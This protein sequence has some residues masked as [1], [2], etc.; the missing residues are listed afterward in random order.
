MNYACADGRIVPA[1]QPLLPASNQGYRYG[2]GLFET[3]KIVNGRISL[4][5]FHFERFFSGLETLQFHRPMHF[6]QPQLEKQILH[7]CKKNQ[8]EKLARVRLSASAGEGGLYDSDNHL[9]YII[10]CWPAADTV[11]ALNE[12]GLVIGIYPAAHKSCDI[13]S[14]LKSANFLPYAMAARY[15]KQRQWNDCLVLNRF[16]RIADSTISN[17]FLVHDGLI[18]TPSL[19]EGCIAGVMRRYLLQQLPLLNYKI[20][21]TTIASEYLLDADEIFLSNAMGIRWVKEL[22]KK[23]YTHSF[24]TGIFKH[25]KTIWE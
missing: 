22:N 16:D 15:A 5:S 1:N 24:T 18:T 20:K 9:H 25:I 2:N 23:Q 17:I 21:E 11:N 10:E 6:D 8:C 3:M 19:E 7:L 14:N 13:F 12:N 4:A